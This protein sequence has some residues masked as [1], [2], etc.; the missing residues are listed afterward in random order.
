MFKQS[1]ISAT[2]HMGFQNVKIQRRNTQQKQIA[3]QAHFKIN[4]KN[5][6]T[7]NM[8]IFS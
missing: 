2:N 4:M 8:C 5:A 7:S 6:V 3:S 1:W